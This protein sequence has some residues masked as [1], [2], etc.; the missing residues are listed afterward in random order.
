MRLSSFKFVSAAAALFCIAASGAPAQQVGPPAGGN[1]LIISGDGDQKTIT[2]DGSNIKDIDGG[3]VVLSVNSNGVLS[4]IVGSP[5]DLP[6]GGMLGPFGMGGPFAAA[7]HGINIVDPGVTY[8]FQLLKRDDVRSELFLDP[9]Q[10]EKLDQMFAGETTAAKERAN[11]LKDSAKAGTVL[12]TSQF[13]GNN[14]SEREKKLAEILTVKQL[15]RLKQLDL[16]FRGPLAMGVKKVAEQANLDDKEKPT[17]ADLLSKYHEAVRKAL[18]MEQKIQRSESTGGDISVSVS[19][20]VNVSGNQEELAQKAQKAQ[21]EIEAARK[22]LSAKA[23]K[24][25]AADHA[26]EWKSLAG[27]RFQ[28]LNIN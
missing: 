28:F 18:G 11:A 21:E 5:M 25:I 19:T 2:I 14:A 13:F 26:A 17:V 15:K 4:T 22:A 9:V 20:S 6:F 10:K 1:V 24:S 27:Q 7:G 3:I 12:K 23:L 8:I 16:Q